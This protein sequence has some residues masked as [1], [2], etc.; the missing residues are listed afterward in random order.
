MGPDLYAT[1]NVLVS[2]GV[3]RVSALDRRLGVL[4]NSAIRDNLEYHVRTLELR[5]ELRANRLV[6]RDIP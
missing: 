1:S 6:I 3:P 2:F 5:V 4:L